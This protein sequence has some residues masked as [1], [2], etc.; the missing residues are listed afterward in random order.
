M[1]AQHRSLVLS[2]EQPTSLEDRDHL[3]REHIEL[4]RQKRVSLPRAAR[5]IP[6]QQVKAQLVSVGHARGG[7]T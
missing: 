3:A 2:A 4:G 6:L 7:L 1:F 5:R